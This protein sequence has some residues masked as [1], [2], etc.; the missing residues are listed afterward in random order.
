MLANNDSRRRNL[1]D[2]GA[3]VLRCIGLS[4]RNGVVYRAF[5]PG[6]FP[7][8]YALTVGK[9]IYAGGN[10]HRRIS[11][12]IFSRCSSAQSSRTERGVCSAPEQGDE[13]RCHE[14]YLHRQHRLTIEDTDRYIPLLLDGSGGRFSSD[15]DGLSRNSTA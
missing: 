13:Q 12:S 1:H 8:V 5:S 9:L 10:P 6:V 11:W 15:F 14:Q 3:H 2:D 7:S 4:S